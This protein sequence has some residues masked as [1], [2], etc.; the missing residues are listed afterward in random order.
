[1]LAAENQILGRLSIS[2]SSVNIGAQQSG[3]L[4]LYQFP[5]VVGFPYGLIT[6]GKVYDHICPGHG[7]SY[8]WRGSRPQILANFRSHGKARHFPA[9]KQQFLHNRNLLS[10]QFRISPEI[11]S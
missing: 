9:G 3:R 1:M 2:G 11:F 8:A 7:V 4:T 10:S 6:G 5:S